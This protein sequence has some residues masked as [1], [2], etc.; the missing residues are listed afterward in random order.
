MYDQYL[1]SWYEVLSE[2]VLDGTAPKGSVPLILALHGTGDDPLMFVDEMGW[3]NIAAK[4]KLAIVAPY[5][6][7]LIIS[8]E[9]GKVAMGVPIYE[10]ILSQVFPIFL[11][12]IL[13]K[14]PAL[15]PTRVYATGYSLGGGSTYARST[16]VW[17]CFRLLYLWQACMTI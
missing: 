9:G 3:L 15:D 17:I 5:E 11:K 14:Y 6:E 10:G 7:E 4:E 13:D 1:Q 16:A 8:H 12:N 2:S